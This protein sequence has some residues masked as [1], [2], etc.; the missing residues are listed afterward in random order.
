[1]PLNEVHDCLIHGHWG[2]RF[3]QEREKDN[4]SAVRKLAERSTHLALLRNR[5]PDT[6]AESTLPVFT[7]K[8]NQVT[9]RYASSWPPGALVWTCMTNKPLTK[10]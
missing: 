7:R 9:D 5:V 10:Y 3:N 4:K 6:T 2:G 8:F 1:M